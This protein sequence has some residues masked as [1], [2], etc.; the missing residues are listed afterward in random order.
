MSTVNPLS[1]DVL[2]GLFRTSVKDPMRIINREGTSI[3][4]KESYNHGGMA[5]YFKTIASFANNVGGYIIFGIGDK[6][7]KLLGLKD[8]NLKQFEDLNVEVFTKNLLEYFSPEIKWDHCTFEFKGLSF[9]VIYT[10]PL[11]NKP[12]ICKKNTDDPN[13]KYSL[14]E[15]DIY[16]RYGGRSERIQYTELNQIIE[17]S[18]KSEERKWIEFA[19]KAVRIGIDNACLL[20]LNNGVMSGTGGS[21]IID[22]KLLEK[23]SFIREGEFVEVKGKPTLRLV[24]DVIGAEAGKLIVGESIRKVVRAIETCDIVRAFLKQEIVDEPLE[25]LKSITTASS[26]NFPFYFLLAQSHIDIADAIRVVE[27]TKARGNSKKYLLKRLEGKLIDPK[28]LANTQSLAADKKREYRQQWINERIVVKN[29]EYK[30]CLDSILALSKE[31][32]EKHFVYI[33][34]KILDIYEKQYENAST[35]LAQSIRN[36]ICFLDETVYVGELG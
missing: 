20:D 13:Q 32:I 30:Y 6:P 7:R 33:S 23:L 31:D 26:A 9:G 25:Y 34:K 11:I 1:A 22:E 21:V 36:A 35:V 29:G 27:E 14:K 3:E 12:C 19:K 4:F 17:S 5:Q 15:G 10:Y 18:R 16:Y 24:G 2:T 28:P 8:K